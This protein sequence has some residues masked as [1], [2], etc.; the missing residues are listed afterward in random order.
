MAEFVEINKNLY[1]NRRYITK[2]VKINDN[3]NVC[4]IDSDISSLHGKGATKGKLN[5]LIVRCV[6]ISGIPDD[7]SRKQHRQEVEKS[8]ALWSKAREN[9]DFIFKVI[10]DEVVINR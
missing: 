4:F 2:Y 7:V 8:E 6:G 10:D 9:P 1:I 3:W 5:M